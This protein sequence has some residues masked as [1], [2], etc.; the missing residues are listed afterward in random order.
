MY[1][2]PQSSGTG[3]IL[4]QPNQP[5]R[6]EA[7]PPPPAPPASPPPPTPEA[8]EEKD[9]APIEQQPEIKVKKTKP[10]YKAKRP[11]KKEKTAHTEPDAAAVESVPCPPPPKKGGLGALLD[12]YTADEILVLAIIILLIM[13]GSDD[14]LVLALCY[15]IL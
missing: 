8:E 13:Q 14:I 15:I 2:R 10:H 4:L 3:K 11:E 6:T 5:Q 7:P 1:T 9:G 12:G